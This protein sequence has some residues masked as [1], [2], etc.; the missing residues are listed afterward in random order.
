MK[1]NILKYKSNIMMTFNFPGTKRALL[2]FNKT[3]HEFESKNRSSKEY[4]SFM[5][6]LSLQSEEYFDIRFID[7]IFP[8]KYK[9]KYPSENQLSADN[10]SENFKSGQFSCVKPRPIHSQQDFQEYVQKD[11]QE[12]VQK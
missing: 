4:N 5:E 7:P 8:S 10:R 6:H 12:Y 9:P 3:I 2:N 11:F 1:S